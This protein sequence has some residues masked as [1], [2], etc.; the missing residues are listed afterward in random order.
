MSLPG[1]RF[2]W[3]CVGVVAVLVGVQV[4]IFVTPVPGV[5]WAVPIAAALILVL[6]KVVG[7]SW[8][9]LGLGR[10]SLGTGL[11]YAAVIIGAVAVVTA[12]GVALPWTRDLFHNDA[13]RDVHAALVSAL[14]L[15]PIYTI[16]A[17][18][19][20][21][22]GVLLGA[23]RRIC[24]PRTALIV[25]AGLFGL[26]HVGSSMGLSAHNQGLGDIVGSGPLATFAGVALAVVVTGGAGILLGWLRIRSG[27]LLAPIALHWSV[28]GLG[29]IAAA[30]AWQLPG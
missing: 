23:L 13:Y 20:I 7:L 16:L 22:R 4:L 30:I 18:E 28:N 2:A 6:A 5:R 3:L 24:S 12:V 25:Q 10:R 27:S 17:E 1:R 15:I 9:D 8:T 19:V 14:V 29:A 21:F 26:W 11:R